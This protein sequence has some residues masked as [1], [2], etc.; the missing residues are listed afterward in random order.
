MSDNLKKLRLYEDLFNADGMTDENSLANALLTQPDV[1]SPVITHLSG[2]EDKRFPLSFLTEGMGNVKYINDIE[3]DYPVMG[4]LNKS[5][6]C[7]GNST[8]SATTGGTVTFNDR[9]FVKNYII[10]FGNA[11]NT[12]LRITADPVQSNGGWTYTV[13]M[14]TSDPTATSITQN[15]LANKQAVQLFAANAFSGSRGNESNWVAPSK[16]RNQISLI[17]KSYRY[18]GNM[19]DRVVNFEFNVGGRSTNLWYDF[20]EYQHMLRWKEE[21]ELA[22]WYSRYNRDSDGLVHLRDENGKVIPLGS[23]V[24]EQIPNVDTYSVL[25]AAK[26]KSV[27]RDALYGASDASQMNIVLFTGLGGME[28]FDNAMKEELASQTYIKNTDPSTFIGGSGR[29]LSLGGFFTQY[30]HIDGHTITVRHLPLFDHG[31]RALAAERHPVTG[32]PLESYRMIFLD[33]SVYDGENNVSMITRK[34]RELVRWAVAGATV[35]PGFGGNALRATD[36]DGSSVHFL[37]ECGISIRRATNCLH[38]E[39]VRS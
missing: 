25:T 23:G 9:W 15:D 14:V 13:Q 29:N 7:V 35:P 26:L 31:A 34:N 20:E 17:R 16:M 11:A 6:M 21:C 5:V 30:Q 24:L 3:Y 38:L 27:V 2:R 28:E 1:L 32:L 12:Q 36:V 33:M 8:I 19:P 18:E 4:R 10:E 22:L 39:C 37:K